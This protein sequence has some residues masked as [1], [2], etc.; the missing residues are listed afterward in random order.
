MS[1]A[2]LSR[3]PATTPI[4][5]L[6]PTKAATTIEKVIF[7][8]IALVTSREPITNKGALE[9]KDKAKG[10]RVFK[11]AAIIINSSTEDNNDENSNDNA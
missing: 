6:M 1:S 11:S 7:K 3:P 4:I 2:P 9:R 10:K 5:A 8:D